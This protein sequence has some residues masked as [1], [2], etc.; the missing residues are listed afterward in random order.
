[1]NDKFLYWCKDCDCFVKEDHR[2]QQWETV[3][4]IP[5][6]AL[7]AWNTQQQPTFD[8]WPTIKEWEE[9]TGRVLQAFDVL[10]CKNPD[11]PLPWTNYYLYLCG[12][13]LDSGELA[14]L[15]IPGLGHPPATWR[16]GDPYPEK[17]GE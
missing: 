8:S 1:M 11:S 7:E 4:K 16:P 9:K 12:P 15:A 3:S 13:L 6:K 2:C 5:T 14:V 17:G 10:W